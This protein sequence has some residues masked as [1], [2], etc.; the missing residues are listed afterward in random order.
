MGKMTFEPDQKMAAEVP[1]F[2]QVAER[3]GVEP[4]TAREVLVALR[5]LGY[6][7]ATPRVQWR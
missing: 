2:E 3:A 4:K 6:T 7:I 5:E 1:L